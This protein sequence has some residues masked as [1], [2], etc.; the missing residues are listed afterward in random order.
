MLLLFLIAACGS[1]GTAGNGNTVFLTAGIT[2]GTAGSVFANI[3]SANPMSITLNSNIYST[4]STVPT[5]DV[6]I[7][8]ITLSFKPLNYSGLDTSGNTVSGLSPTFSPQYANNPQ[9]IG[10]RVPA[11]GTLKIDGIDILG[12]QD[13]ITLRLDF[14]NLGLFSVSFN[15]TANITFH[16]VEVNTGKGLSVTL[17]VG[18]L[19]QET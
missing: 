13:L 8:A 7:D 6:T 4:T 12:P 2:T 11:G 17:P 5:S 9:G 16:G 15:Y 1:G 14:L 18:V 19:V 10:G 3:S